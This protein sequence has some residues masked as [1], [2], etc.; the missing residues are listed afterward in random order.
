[1]A[2]TEN[3]T[4]I[5][6]ARPGAR[7]LLRR[8]L[9]TVVVLLALNA[10]RMAM[11]NLRA[12]PVSAAQAR[13]DVVPYTVTLRETVVSSS[14]RRLAAP[15][16]TLA[17]R[18]DGATVL[19]IGDGD[20]ST[21]HIRFP[22]GITVEVSDALRAR[23]TIYRPGKSSIRA[24]RENCTKTVDGEVAR[25]GQSDATLAHVSGYRA[26]RITSGG[27]THWFALDY[28]C[29]LL[30]RIVDSG[31]QGSSHLELVTLI[32]GEPSEALFQ[33]PDE[34]REGAPS[35]FAPPPPDA[36][37]ARCAESRKAH[38]ERLDRS[39]YRNRPPF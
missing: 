22:S 23:S 29:A 34:Y 32:P 31:A 37:N 3:A 28:G 8:A 20:K 14:G 26:V 21:R 4:R 30:E 39:Y 33:V 27:T 35:R 17:V 25:E 5:F 2:A 9:Y 11:P 6:S 13:A 24:P 38:F 15:V 18:S 1:M 10:V 19:R 12:L 16:Q 7:D 36:S